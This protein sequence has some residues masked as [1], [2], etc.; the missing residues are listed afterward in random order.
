M[1]TDVHLVVKR[2]CWWAGEEGGG[3]GRCTR[4][5]IQEDV[6]SRLDTI[7]TVLSCD[8][9]IRWGISE[10]CDRR[11]IVY[12]VLYVGRRHQVKPVDAIDRISSSHIHL[13]SPEFFGT[14]N[15]NKSFDIWTVSNK[16]ANTHTHRHRNAIWFG[17][18]RTFRRYR[19]YRMNEKDA[20]THK[21]SPAHRTASIFISNAFE[22]ERKQ[23]RVGNEWMYSST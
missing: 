15:S 16:R 7:F 5:K 18:E 3:R 11:K 4:A 1:S 10:R 21:P 13:E 20:R 6:D 9:S 22:I 19:R 14:N 23:T 2:E 12:F 17:L 8:L